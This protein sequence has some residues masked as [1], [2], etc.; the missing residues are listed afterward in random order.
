[1]KN[2]LKIV[3]DVSMYASVESL[4]ESRVMK[5]IVEKVIDIFEKKYPN[6]N[7]L[8]SHINTNISLITALS[9]FFVLLFALY[10]PC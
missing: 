7:T 3:V 1:M 8:N 4:N 2:S 10:F 9:S 5:D 6:D